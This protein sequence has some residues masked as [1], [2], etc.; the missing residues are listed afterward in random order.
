MCHNHFFL[1]LLVKSLIVYYENSY[2]VKLCGPLLRRQLDY[3]HIN[4]QA[5]NYYAPKTVKTAAYLHNQQTNVYICLTSPLS[6]KK[7]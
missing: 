3:W 2:I 6:V 1:L 4:S 7:N 5:V